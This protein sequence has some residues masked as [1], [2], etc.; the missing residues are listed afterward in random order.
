MMNKQVSA[1]LYYFLCDASLPKKFLMELLQ[2]TCNATLVAEIHDCDWN[3][4]MQTITTLRKKEENQDIKDFEATAWYK[5]AFDLRGLGKSMTPAV[6]RA[7]EALFDLDAK[8]SVK[9]STTVI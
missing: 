6:T 9:L 5:Q 7:P 3:M 2:E 4:K 1:F 8:Q